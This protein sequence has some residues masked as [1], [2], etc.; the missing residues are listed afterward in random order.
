MKKS[1]KIPVGNTRPAVHGV[2]ND[3]VQKNID[4]NYLL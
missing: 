1:E 3:T 2:V 4:Y